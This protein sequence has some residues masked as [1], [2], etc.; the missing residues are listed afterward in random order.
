MKFPV[1]LVP[2]L[3]LAGCLVVSGPDSRPGWASNDPSQPSAPPLPPAVVAAAPS[4]DD[5][6]IV[7]VYADVLDRRPS[8]REIRSWQERARGQRVS[9]DDLRRALR[10]APEFQQV[11]DAVIRRAFMDY[12]HVQPDAEVLSLYRRRM[13]DDDWG[14]SRVREDIARRNTDYLSPPPPG[15][16]RNGGDNNRPDGRDHNRH[17]EKNDRRGATPPH[18]SGQDAQSLDAIV[19]RAYRDVLERKPD[20]AGRA[21]YL[22]KL[23]QGASEADIRAAL[24]ASEEFRVTLPDAKTRRAYQEILGRD[25]DEGGLHHYRSLIVDK[26]WTEEDVKNDLRKSAEYRN[27]KH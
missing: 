25:A 27:R 6:E 24:R 1:V 11:P 14:V 8:E 12:H 26:G 16:A 9:P 2:A 13:I 15:H 23:E 20:P 10:G 7:Q 22:Q 3:L 4:L 19:T 21:H 18:S 5:G 17:D